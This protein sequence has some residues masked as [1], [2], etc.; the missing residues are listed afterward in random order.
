MRDYLEAA[1][2]RFEKQFEDVVTKRNEFGKPSFDA[3]TRADIGS[4]DHALSKKVGDARTTFEYIRYLENGYINAID[5]L[6]KATV[7]GV[8]DIAGRTGLA[9]LENVV[10]ATE[11]LNPT[12]IG[13][14]TA[15]TMY[16]A[17]NPV[18]QL[19]L[20]S[21]QA[22][23]LGAMFPK[24]M[25]TDVVGDMRILVA[26]MRNK[27]IPKSLLKQQGVTAEQAARMIKDFKNSGLFAAVDANN[28][29]RGDLKKLA[30]LSFAG[31]TV[32][33]LGAPIRFSQRV[34]FDAGEQVN[35]MTSWLAHRNDAINKH[36]LKGLTP[37]VMDEVQAQARNFTYN[38]NQAGD[39]PYNQN[40]L[41]ILFQF[42]QVPHKGFTQYFNR[43][44]DA[45]TRVKMAT[46]DT[47]MW[48]APAV[49]S[50]PLISS[51]LPD[52]GPVREVV[53][54]GLESAILNMSIRAITGDDTSIDFSSLAPTDA[55][56]IYSVLGEVWTS[57][58]GTMLAEAPAGQLFFGNNPRITNFFKT[59]A[60]ATN[61][62][63]DYEDPTEFG[64]VAQA[65]ALMSSGYS[66]WFKA[67]YMLETGQKLNSVADI[68]DYSTTTMESLAQA[69]GFGTT[70]ER[71]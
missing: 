54:R 37:E 7:D 63:D 40:H 17:L 60:R 67:K 21:H 35:I 48:G 16:L 70:D 12:Q 69:F 52:D 9:P 65:F 61:L 43:A 24:Y 30:D 20:Q 5:G 23:R 49:A 47:V 41:N 42:L 36:G 25:A 71:L 19:E 38:M 51:I 15:F 32:D 27:P 11:R 29:V 8:A 39:M 6:Y 66:S 28:L 56:G 2:R 68:S 13:K 45:K 53:E 64:E 31:K 26:G 57:D 22:V 44:L 14:S 18:R 3:M 55:I 4:P 10:R 58:L 46:F 33:A 62:I 34:G 59:A 1:K 50:I